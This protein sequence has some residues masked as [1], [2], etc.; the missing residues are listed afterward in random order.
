MWKCRYGDNVPDNP[1]ASANV[2]THPLLGIGGHTV[3]TRVL[4]R[5]AL[6]WLHELNG[7]EADVARSYYAIKLL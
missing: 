2:I 4:D 1:H 6:E 7:V 3:N 5:A